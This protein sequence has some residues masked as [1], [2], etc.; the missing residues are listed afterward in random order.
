MYPLHGLIVIIL[1]YKTLPFRPGLG[2]LQFFPQV[3]GLL[4]IAEDAAGVTR[5][6]FQ[7]GKGLR[8]F[9]FGEGHFFGDLVDL[10]AAGVLGDVAQFAAVLGDAVEHVFD[11]VAG[12]EIVH[13][14]LLLGGGFF[15]CCSC[16]AG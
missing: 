8:R 6:A 7:Q 9:V 16:A 11:A 2:F 13:S 4:G 12:R 3:L 1:F 10:A 14:G 5:R 15:F